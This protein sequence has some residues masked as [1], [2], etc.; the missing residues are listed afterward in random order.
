[1]WKIAILA[2]VSGLLTYMP[3]VSQTSRKHR[4]PCPVKTVPSGWLT[5][6]DRLHGFCFSYPPT[7]EPVAEPWLEKYTHAP[8]KSAL[9]YLRKAA[10][11]GRM[12]RLQNKQDAG[13]S[14]DVFLYN[15]RPFD[16]ESFV[17][18]AP[19]G[20]ESPPERREF[21][22][23]TFY[24]YGPGGGGVDYPDQ[25]FFN[26]KG[27]TLLIAFDGP[28][29]DDKTPSRRPRRSKDNYSRVSRRSS[30]LPAVLSDSPQATASNCGPA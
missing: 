30:A 18:G 9:D 4:E 22:T 5:Y 28:Y 7:H 11:Q 13:V 16:L 20:I 2:T 6:V 27:K 29:I 3:A 23:E 15:D 8:N 17:S 26:L 12:L 24:Y 14:I 1:M 21:G 19:T 10:K 25:Y